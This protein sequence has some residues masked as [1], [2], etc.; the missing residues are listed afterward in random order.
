MATTIQIT[1]RLQREL[2]RRKLYDGEAYED[3]IW[4]L[5]EDDQEL[6][7]ETKKELAHARAEIKAGRVHTL[8][9]V[10]KKLGL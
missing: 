10:R 4:D 8:S 6:S 5:V 3:V 2:L 9:Q 1:E 7:E